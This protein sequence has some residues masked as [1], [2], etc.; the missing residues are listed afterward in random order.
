MKHSVVCLGLPLPSDLYHCK[1][2][3]TGPLLAAIHTFLRLHESL[4]CLDSSDL[5]AAQ[6]CPLHVL[7]GLS[8]NRDV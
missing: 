2:D 1:W 8:E 6:I 7:R 3:G 5:L 4:L